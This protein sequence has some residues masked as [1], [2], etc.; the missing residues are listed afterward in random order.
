MS[1]VYGFL[2]GLHVVH[3]QGVFHGDIKPENI[4]MG[5]NGQLRIADFGMAKLFENKEDKTHKMWGTPAYQA[6]EISG[7]CLQ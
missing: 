5:S 6:P 2:C 3:S 4:L 7:T 1:H